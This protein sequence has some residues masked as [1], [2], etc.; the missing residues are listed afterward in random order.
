[1]LITC[2][3]KYIYNIT[4]VVQCSCRWS[5]IAARLPGRTDNEIKN[6]WNSTLK[7][8]LRI[9]S[10]TSS[11]NNSESMGCGD[12]IGGS[13]PMQENEI[14]ATG[15]DLSLPPSGFQPMQN[16][17]MGNQ[18]VDPLSPAE[19]CYNHYG[20]NDV[21]GGAGYFDVMPTG[22]AEGHDLGDDY[23]CY[24]DL[25][26]SNPGTMEF[27]LAEIYRPPFG[28]FSGS[29]S[30]EMSKSVCT[31]LSCSMMDNTGND[32]YSS[33]FSND[34]CF[35]KNGDHS[36]NVAGISEGPWDMEEGLGEDISS[37]SS[38]LLERTV[39]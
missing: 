35:N 17:F 23:Y 28:N 10:I 6:F 20:R 5:Q 13:R 39:C 26:N 4:H 12:I 29:S 14:A 32:D 9:E 3:H 37:S 33:Y 24:G 30:K 38:A 16:M 8:R 19:Y 7:K 25:E 11:P 34:N 15:L 36:L 2:L 27:G 31:G 1:M 18:R 21:Y 22:A